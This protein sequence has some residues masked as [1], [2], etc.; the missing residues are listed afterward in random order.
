MSRPVLYSVVEGSGPVV[1]LSHALGCDHTM[2]DGVAA[3]LL[4]HFTVVRYDHRGH[5]QSEAPPGPYSIDM[6]ADDAAA[7]I[8][9]LQ[10]GPVHFVGLSMGGMTVQALAARHPGLVKSITIA[11]AALHYDDAARAMWRARV[12][13]VLANGVGSIADGAMQRWFTPEFRADLRMG[14]GAARVAAL[15]AR[16]EQLD[17]RAYAASCL[18]VSQ[19]DFR[20]SNALVKCPALVFAGTRD[21]ATPVAMSEVIRDSIAGAQLQTIPAAHLSAV[22]QPEAFAGLLEKFFAEQA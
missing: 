10:K 19:I 17:A 6:L 2:W 13:T 8:G 5:G 11:N 12:D 18:A 7:L 15:R 16:L 14:G 21:E 9:D 4:R 20:A 1:V 22:E 3:Q